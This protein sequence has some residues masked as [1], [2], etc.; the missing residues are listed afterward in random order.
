MPSTP[1]NAKAA[2][3][4]HNPSASAYSVAI[5]VKRLI[6]LL[7]PALSLIHPVLRIIIILSTPFLFRP[8]NHIV[9]TLLILVLILLIDIS[10]LIHIVIIILALAISLPRHS[11]AI[12]PLELLKRPSLVSMAIRPS[13]RLRRSIYVFRS[14]VSVDAVAV[15]AC[16]WRSGLALSGLCLLLDAATVVVALV[17]LDFVV[18]WCPG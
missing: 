15:L 18:L 5:I 14:R 4:D 9:P 16:P 3:G 11:R 1:D 2:I 8:G 12:L 13:R 6:P 7:P 17:A 10:R